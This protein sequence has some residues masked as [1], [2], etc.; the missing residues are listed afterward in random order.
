M[1]CAPNSQKFTEQ[2]RFILHTLLLNAYAHPIRKNI[3]KEY[4]LPHTVP[5]WYVRRKHK[6]TLKE[7]GLPHT[8]AE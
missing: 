2:K 6:S 4:G 3:L 1:V 8:V 7:Y 5:E